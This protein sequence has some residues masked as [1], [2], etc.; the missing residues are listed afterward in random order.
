MSDEDVTLAPASLAPDVRRPD[1]PA[2]PLGGDGRLDAYVRDDDA[3]ARHR[4]LLLAERAIAAKYM[5]LGQRQAWPY[6]VGG[7]VSFAGW[8]ALWPQA[9]HR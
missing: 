9:H 1:A 7:L 3:R 8:V 2:L 5:A 6:A 4:E